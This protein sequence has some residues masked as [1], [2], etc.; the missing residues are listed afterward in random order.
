VR[1][2]LLFFHP[3][4]SLAFTPSLFS[5]LFVF[6]HFVL[7]YC[8]YFYYFCVPY[9]F[10]LFPAVLF[11]FICLLFSSFPHSLCFSLLLLP[12]L[13]PFFLRFSL[14][15]F[16]L[17]IILRSSLFPLCSLLLCYDSRWHN[18]CVYITFSEYSFFGPATDPGELS[19]SVISKHTGW[20][21]KCHTID[22]A[23]NTL[24]LLLL[25]LSLSY[26]HYH[27]H[28][29]PLWSSGQSFWLQIQRSRVRFPALPDFS[30]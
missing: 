3:D 10:P 11:L 26:Y 18:S 24:L 19:L 5:P 13:L 14:F 27:H 30:E 8:S 23:R 1:K 16:P 25:S 17:C 29:P 22:C 4:L 15:L 9:S 28:R 20:R 21:T 7:F 12:A 6:L 2:Y